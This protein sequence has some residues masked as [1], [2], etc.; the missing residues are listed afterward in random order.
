ME[1]L[2]YAVGKAGSI[3]FRR[4]SVGGVELYSPFANKF[5]MSITSDV[6]YA[7]ASGSRAVRFDSN[8]QGTITLDFDVFEPKLLAII[9]GGTDGFVDG[10]TSIFG[11]EVKTASTAITLASPAIA[12]SVSIYELESDLIGHKAEIVETTST[13][14]AGEFTVSGVD[15]VMHADD[16]G[17]KIVIYY[18]KLSAITASKYSINVSEFPEGYTVDFVTTMKAKA[19]GSLA[20][21]NII[22]RNATPMT[23]S[24]LSFTEGS[25]TTLSVTLDLFP[26]ANLNMCEVIKVS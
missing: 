7:M 16:V 25:H 15:V 10:A 2:N 8:K 14:T 3:T 20:N 4:N 13:P 21:V 24:T 9:F 19:T 26:D 1:N 17:K 23:D 6:D 11:R 22:A 5:D 12:D 18:T